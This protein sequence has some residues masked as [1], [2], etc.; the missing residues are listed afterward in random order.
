MQRPLIVGL[1]SPHGDD[2]AGWLIVE[3]LL[4]AGISSDNAKTAAHPADLLDWCDT[5]RPLFVCDACASVG[6]PGAIHR[7][8]WPGELP[9][10]VKFRGSHDLPLIPVLELGAQLGRLPAKVVVWGIT[11][12]AFQPDSPMSPAVEEATRRLAAR[13]MFEHP[14]R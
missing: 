3:H 2:R 13:L 8:D 12:A 14:L 7:W 6:T 4:A 11:G 9:V 10:D 1:G 5:A